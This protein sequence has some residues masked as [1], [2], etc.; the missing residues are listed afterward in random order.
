MKKIDLRHAS[1]NFPTMTQ[2]EILDS[3]QWEISRLST[4]N[5]PNC[6]QFHGIYQNQPNTRTYIVMEFCDGGTLQGVLKKSPSL[7]KRWQWSME[8]SQGLAYLHG[9]GIIHRDLKSENVL[10]DTLGCAKLADLGVSQVDSLVENKTAIVVDQGLQDQRFIAPENVSQPRLSNQATDIYALGLV[11]W[12]IISGGVPQLPRSL[13]AGFLS[14]WSDG[15]IVERESIPSDCPLSY[16]KLIM[17]C[18]NNSPELRPN[19]QRII[20]DLS[21]MGEELNHG[22]PKLFVYCQKLER[23]V[24]PK[25]L[26]GLY[27]LAPYVTQFQVTEPIETYWSTYETNQKSSSGN[28]P[29]DLF[30]TFKN[31]LNEKE[32]RVLLFFGGSGLGKSLSTFLFAIDILK[33]WWNYLNQDGKKPNYL[34][35]FIRPALNSWNFSE[36]K[37]A[38]SKVIDFWGL[39]KLDV[40]FLIIIDGYDE[41]AGNHSHLYNL[42][43]HLGLPDHL[44][45]KLIITCRPAIFPKDKLM[46][47]FSFQK[48][49]QVYYFLPFKTTQIL[50]YVSKKLGWT[51]KT[52]EDYQ[53]QLENSPSLRGI[54]RNPFVLSLFVESWS[55]VSKR[56][57]KQ[58]KKHQIYDCFLEHWISSYKHLLSKNVHKILV[59]EFGNLQESFTSFASEIAFLA[60]KNN[61]IVLDPKV[62]VHSAWSSLE[63]LILKD[64]DLTYSNPDF[65]LKLM[66]INQPDNFSASYLE[67]RGSE[68][69]VLIRLEKEGSITYHCYSALKD[70]SNQILDITLTKE[71][72]D[73]FSD[74]DKESIIRLS[75]HQNADLYVKISQLSKLKVSRRS[76]LTKTDYI[77]LKNSH[78]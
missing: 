22:E 36:L 40:P 16:H 69:P 23:F 51:E 44:E 28:P 26:E 33:D 24:Y 21:G 71:S 9:Q 25:K 27:Y 78:L 65:D 2:F 31:F 46:D 3:L 61:N 53:V 56:N 39:G 70:G 49:L 42:P 11:F 43:Q 60:F 10:L 58:L 20:E 7:S 38:F 74:C 66:K 12:Q 59:G 50:S 15:S 18:W 37:G 57:F 73:L 32:Q 48:T 64:S 1:R 63:A 35:L 75:I 54:L 41:C 52:R 76:V 17:D 67:R 55:T 19:V 8:V 47:Y 68:P 30:E 5:H 14:A 29:L 4:V 34:P 45:C 62:T 6:V 72:E 13:G 77:Q